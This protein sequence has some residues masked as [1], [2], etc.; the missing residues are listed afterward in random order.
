MQQREQHTTSVLAL[1][2]ALP[3]TLLLGA[4]TA[5]DLGSVREEAAYVSIRQHAYKKLL[6]LLLLL[7]L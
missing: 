3:L 5:Y 6:L 2:L 1:T 4:A 7:S